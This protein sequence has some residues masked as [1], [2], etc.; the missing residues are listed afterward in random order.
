MKD[1]HNRY[2]KFYGKRQFDIAVELFK[3][4]RWFKDPHE[5][6]TLGYIKVNQ[7]ALE[8]GIAMV[9]STWVIK[10]NEDITLVLLHKLNEDICSEFKLRMYVMQDELM[11]EW[12]LTTRCGDQH[13][14]DYAEFKAEIAKIRI[15][16][17][18]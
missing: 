2:V 9:T 17:I 3:M 11:F 4:T 14:D 16:E 13:M 7:M 8:D 12:L 5:L 6:E 15:G 18:A 1:I 10:S